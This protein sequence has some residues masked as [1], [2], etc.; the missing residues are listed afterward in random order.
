MSDANGCTSRVSASSAAADPAGHQRRCAAMNNQRT[1]PFFGRPMYGR[2]TGVAAT[3]GCAHQVALKEHA[4]V[5]AGARAR[6]RQRGLFSLFPWPLSDATAGAQNST[7]KH[8]S[9]PAASLAAAGLFFSWD[10]RIFFINPLTV[11]ASGGGDGTP[12]WI[13]RRPE[14]RPPPGLRNE[15]VDATANQSEEPRH[16]VVISRHP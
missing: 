11:T 8:T 4:P 9:V 1:N 3:H 5:A 14:C 13:Q 7:H 12:A 6:Q 2:G 10:T 15:E 16:V